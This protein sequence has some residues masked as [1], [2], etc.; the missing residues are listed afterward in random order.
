MLYENGP[1]LIKEAN[2]ST[3][4]PES[5]TEEFNVIYLDQ[6]AGVG[7]SYLDNV[8]DE[9][10]Y[11]SRTPESSLDVVAFIRLFYE[12]FPN[13]AS[14]DLHLGGESFAGRYVPSVAAAILDFNEF[15]S[16][17]DPEII[18]L[19]SIMVGNPMISPAIQ[20]PTLYDVSCYPYRGG[21]Y[22]EHMDPEDC[23]ELRGVVDRCEALLQACAKSGKDEILCQQ[24][25]G[26][27]KDKFLDP[28]MNA[29]RSVYDRRRRNCPSPGS[30]YPDVALIE[31]Y[32]NSKEVVENLIEAPSQS[33]GRKTTWEMASQLIMKR[34]I[35]SGD[36]NQPTTPQIER[37]LEYTRRTVPLSGGR[38]VD[39]M[40]YV[41]T[42][43]I[44]CNAEGVLAAMT[45]VRWDGRTDF[46]AEPWVELPWTAEGG[47][48]A[49]RA[50]G[51]KNFYLVEIEEAGHMV[52]CLSSMTPI[53]EVLT[54]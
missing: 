33:G 41:G 53:S 44:I 28:F 5:W 45:S 6:P 35:E 2:T 18:P 39:V 13:L 30:C 46:R 29:S 31:V 21:Q 48:R 3:Y 49:G 20:I 26:L 47:G 12:A 38:P 14:T 16:P 52:S 17:Q 19:R 23:S 10:A 51:T 25:N 37:I 54:H 15:F 24:P 50:K 27:C 36:F 42:T 34:Y 4:N 8:D 22:P 40:I 7:F 9:H 32:L 11:P 1:C 43:D